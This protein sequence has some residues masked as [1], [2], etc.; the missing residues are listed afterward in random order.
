MRF[1]EVLR[2]FRKSIQK[3]AG[4][5]CHAAALTGGRGRSAHLGLAEPHQ[6]VQALLAV[7]PE[8]A[9]Q[10]RHLHH[11]RRLPPQ[12][13]GLML[14]PESSVASLAR[15][16]SVSGIVTLPLTTLARGPRECHK[17]RFLR[18]TTQTGKCPKTLFFRYRTRARHQISE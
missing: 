14:T 12:G 9:R 13:S 3:F 10:V 11:V 8:G 6:L 17:R 5:G 16:V 15:R 2:E 1:L 7:Q 4:L 18:F